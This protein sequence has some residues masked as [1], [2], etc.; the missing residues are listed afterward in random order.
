M[1]TTYT[2]TTTSEEEARTALNAGAMQAILWDLT[3]V[4][5]RDWLKHGHD[6]TDIDSAL[7]AVRELVFDACEEN[8]I[9]L[10]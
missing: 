4:K 2:F 3:N 6:F 7:E 5:I 9:I 1:T 10:E 8:G